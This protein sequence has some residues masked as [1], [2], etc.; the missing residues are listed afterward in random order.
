[1]KK[2]REKKH[3]NTEMKSGRSITEKMIGGY[4]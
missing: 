1:M 3:N 2:F 4:A